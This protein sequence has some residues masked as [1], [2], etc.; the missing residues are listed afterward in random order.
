MMATMIQLPST[1]L[2]SEA[3]S[4]YKAFSLQMAT[5]LNLADAIR[6]LGGSASSPVSAE[7]IGA[8]VVGLPPSRVLK[9]LRPLANSYIF[10]ETT[11]NHF[12]NNRASLHLLD[13]CD[14]KQ[15]VP[16]ASW[17]HPRVVPS[18]RMRG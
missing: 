6:T 15:Y 2:M 4:T 7:A 13:E 5:S 1:M 9:V 3:M 12:V 16:Y 14:V 8:R 10:Q 11:E 18:I 17:I